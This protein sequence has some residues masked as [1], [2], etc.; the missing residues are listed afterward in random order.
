MSNSQCTTDILPAPHAS[1]PRVPYI[2]QWAEET[3]PRLNFTRRACLV[4]LA[5]FC[6]ES[7]E[8]WPPTELL[9]WRLDTDTSTIERC[10]QDLKRLGLILVERVSVSDDLRRNHCQLAG[11]QTGW[12][13]KPKD[14]DQKPTIEEAAFARVAE[15]EAEVAH[16]KGR[17][18]S[19]TPGGRHD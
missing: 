15:L 4:E 19:G 9:A 11:F 12:V 18:I 6:S 17:T 7:G 14:Q 2:V 3:G 13:P 8:C 5:K 1:L 16:I 10:V